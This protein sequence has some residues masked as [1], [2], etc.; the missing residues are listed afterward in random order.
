[1]VQRSWEVAYQF[2]WGSSNQLYYMLQQI[3]VM[4]Y[5]LFLGSKTFVHYRE[6]QYLCQYHLSLLVMLWLPRIR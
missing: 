4:E 1:M 5:G 6:W 2:D 3:R